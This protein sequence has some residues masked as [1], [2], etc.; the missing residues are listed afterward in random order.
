MNY[1]FN[2]N[3]YTKWY[4]Q[5]MSNI[6]QC[7]RSKKSSTYYEKH[8]IIPRSIGGDNKKE[9]LILLTA[10]EHYIAHML[11]V[12]MVHHRDTYKM[13]HAVIRFSSKVSS[14]RQYE[15]LRK[16]VSNNSKGKFNHS[17]NKV[18]IHHPITKQILYVD[19]YKFF[20]MKEY[21][22]FIK[23]LPWQRG[24]KPKGYIWINNGVDEGQQ[25]R[26]QEI[27]APWVK[28]RLF[29]HSRTHM[30]T[31]SKKRHSKEKDFEHS[32]KLTNRITVTHPVT[33]ITKRIHYQQLNDYIQ[34]GFICGISLTSLSKQCEIYGVLFETITQ[35]A[36]YYNMSPQTVM[37]RLKSTSVK[38]SNWI[39]KTTCIN[40]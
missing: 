27:I 32:I 31:M 39:L 12:K 38:W 37:Y 16:L 24:G 8:H 11:L 1:I 34:Q 29:H 13:V 4:Y 14:A 28:G 22:E 3:K 19:K 35:A 36:R 18:W 40:T 26:D 25:P 6:R 20:E 2:D 30:Q 21:H 23:G 17:F 5:M 10:R 33:K 9:N 7:D 15:N